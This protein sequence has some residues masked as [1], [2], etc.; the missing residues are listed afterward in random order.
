MF[1]SLRRFGVALS[2]AGLALVAWPGSACAQGSLSRAQQHEL[3]LYERTLVLASP[4]AGPA[5]RRAG[6][7]RIATALPIW[8]LQ[9]RAALRVLPGLLHAGLVQEVEPDRPLRVANHLVDP[10]VGQEWWIPFVGLDRAPEPPGPG[11]PVTIIDTG[12][13]LTHEEFAARPAT[14]AFNAQSTSARF[15]EHGTAVASVAAAPTNSVGLVGVYP[16]AALRVWDAS[17]L[18]DGIR[19]G[20]V[21]NG[22]DAAIRNGPSVINLSLGSQTR[23]QLFDAMIAYAIGSGSVVVA[24]AGN[25]RT[26]GSP[27]EYPASLPHVLTVGAIDQSGQPTSFTSGSPYVDLAAPG[28]N[29][30]VAV[31]TAF[32][33]TGYSTFSGTSFSSPMV[34]GAAAWVWTARPT[35]DVTQL[36]EVM[37]ASAQ[38]ISS[39]GFDPFSGFG[40]LDIPAAL[41]VAPGAP[42]P[43]EPNEDVSYL[44][45]T[46]ILH[47]A[48]APLTAAGRPRGT[49][50]ARLDFAEDPRDVYRIWVPGK[51]TAFVALQPAGGDIDLGLWGPRT[52][53]VLE[54]G[55]ARK[56][57]AR[58]ISERAGQK[59]ELLR[60][61]NTGRRGAY[62]YAEA[63]VGAGNGT[64]VRRAAGIGYRLSVSI[65]K[66]KT[67]R[68]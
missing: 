6:G 24:A 57:D 61:K 15:D 22:L 49:L 40:R 44:K 16:R 35:L 33:S 28:F 31:P 25:S 30:P 1:A 68:R 52:L 55:A 34:T 17:P 37:R 45:R 42:D 29:I 27:L 14:A 67:A 4:G 64:V 18:G 26:A 5:L 65:V 36:L 38:D 43:Q 54:A 7:V 10:L 2:L 59:R 63:S 66:T 9:S 51:R 56:R 12:V 60:V 53:S 50:A 62:Y 11:K 3:R 46:G 20:D 19:A 13:D 21:I 8:G 47:R 41:T 48:A 39:P 58:G 23:V 32:S